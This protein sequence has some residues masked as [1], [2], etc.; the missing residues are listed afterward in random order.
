VSAN[1]L[2]AIAKIKEALDQVRLLSGLLPIC[3]S[4]KRINDGREVWQ[5]LEAYV[6][7]HSEAKFSHGVCP[8][9]LRKLY[10]EYYPQ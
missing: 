9:C 5:P 4:C 10:P 1:L 3:A 8:D 2:T 6:Q 7:A